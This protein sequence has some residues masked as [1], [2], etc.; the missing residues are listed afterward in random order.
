MGLPLE[1]Q[2]LELAKHMG[3]LMGIFERVDL[4]DRLPRNI[5]FV[6]IRVRVDPWSLVLAGFMLRLDDGFRVWVQCRYERIHKLCKRCGLI[7]T[8]G[9]SVQRAWTV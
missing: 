7:G 2:Y 8:L 1:Y 4:E 9:G 3:Q 5:R 6:R